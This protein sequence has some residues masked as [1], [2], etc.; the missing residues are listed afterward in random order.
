M[1]EKNGIYRCEMCGNVFE[2]VDAKGGPIVCCGEEMKLLVA[3]TGEKEG[4]EK[5]VPVIEIDGD[6]VTVKVGSIPHPMEE[7]H[8]IMLIEVMHGGRVIAGYWPAPGEKPEA[9]FKLS[10]TEGIW[11]R[12]YCN[13]HGLWKDG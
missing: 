3:K 7:K 5:H 4:K 8:Y 12:A 10:Q 2:A 11:A 9:E 6:K 13:V 1:V